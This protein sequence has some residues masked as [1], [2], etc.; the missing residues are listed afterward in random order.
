MNKGFRVLPSFYEAIRP[1]PDED[2]LALWDAIMDFAFEGVEPEGLSSIQ[3]T[4]FVLLR[5]I[6]EKSVCY[7]EKQ[8]ING[9]KGGRPPKT[10]T[11]PTENPNKTQMKPRKKLDIDN[12][13]DIES[14]NERARA[15]KPPRSRFSPPTVEQVTEYCRE[16]GNKIDPQRFIDYYS[17]IGWMVGKSKMKDWQ[18]AVR[19]WEQRE[20]AKHGGIGNKTDDQSGKFSELAELGSDW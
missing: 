2:R 6:I 19:T 5:P 20:G 17:S 3:K 18:A 8:G 13:S 11:K 16:R 4:I 10:Q 14:D 15:D 12:D 7:Y 1:L 9:A